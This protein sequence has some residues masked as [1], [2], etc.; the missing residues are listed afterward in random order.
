MKFIS[1]FCILFLLYFFS[2]NCGV[3]I[4]S[5]KS[6]DTDSVV[7]IKI[8]RNFPW[9]TNEGKLLS[10]E[11][12]NASIFYKKDL[13][14]YKIPYV[15]KIY[16]LSDSTIYEVD[17]VE[18]RIKYFV[19]QKGDS[20]G[21]FTDSS[22][23]IHFFQCPTDSMFAQFW[24]TQP[25]LEPLLENFHYARID[26]LNF[27]KDDIFST[28]YFFQ[29]KTDSLQKGTFT[30]E[31]SPSF[32][33]VDYSICQRLDTIKEM[34]L[35]NARVF[36]EAR[37]VRKYNVTIDA[38]DDYQRLTLFIDFNLSEITPFFEFMQRRNQKNN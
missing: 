36:N 27:R 33:S 34:K 1:I 11:Q 3:Y 20:I 2:I 17:K 7:A 19:Y 30:L 29:N 14:L 6:F 12:E 5:T 13:V 28:T 37:Y 15:H 35:I 31:F 9:M 18:E 38:V 4:Q 32:P 26:S 21:Y 23:N 16:K 24:P 22:L 8:S 25:F 10:Y